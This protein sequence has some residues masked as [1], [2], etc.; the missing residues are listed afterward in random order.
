MI[1][2]VLIREGKGSALTCIRFRGFVEPALDFWI[3]EIVKSDLSICKESEI[4]RKFVVG[5][6]FPIGN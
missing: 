3:H 4:L 6:G 2:E 5:V 1:E